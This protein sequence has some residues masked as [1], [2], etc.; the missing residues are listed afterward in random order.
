MSKILPLPKLPT[1]PKF[2]PHPVM[3]LDRIRF[4]LDDDETFAAFYWFMREYPRIYRHHL[5]HAELRLK[6]IYQKYREAHDTFTIEHERM[7]PG[8]FD[9]A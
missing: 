6:E 9:F 4:Q 1:F 7:S 2:S 3:V 5:D 8:L